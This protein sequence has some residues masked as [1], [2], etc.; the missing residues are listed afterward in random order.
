LSIL[1]SSRGAHLQ[2]VAPPERVLAVFRLT[3]LDR[4]FVWVEPDWAAGPDG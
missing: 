3:R 4:I 2:L 1:A